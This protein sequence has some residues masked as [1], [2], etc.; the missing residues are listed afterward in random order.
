MAHARPSR[1]LVLF[2]GD[3]AEA[4]ISRLS[5]RAVADAL[6]AAG[7]HVRAVDLPR[8]DAESLDAALAAG[9]EDVVFPALHGPW[10]EGG[11]LQDLLAARGRA[12]VGADAETARLCM[13]KQRTKERAA[14]AGVPVIEGGVVGPGEPSP[15]PPPAVVK[16]V[17]DGS[18][19]DLV[20]ADDAAALAEALARIT[21]RRGRV[22]VERRIRGR[23]ITVGMLNGTALPLV[24]IVPAAGAYDYAAKYE[25]ADTRYRTAPDDL[26]AAVADAAVR[27]AET[28]WAAL[29]L[30]DLAR[31]DFMV[32]GD[33]PRLLEV[34]TMPGFTARSLLPRAAAAAGYDLPRL[35]AHLADLAAARGAP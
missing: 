27:A 14:A 3:D 31:V 18:S 9:D 30:R 8:G 6:L 34:N 17:D 29:G 21:A 23:E 4:P 19:V 25:R 5:G 35:T 10:G 20:L 28:V 22:L 7:R 32:D 26:P 33:T 12:F 1:V 15:V 24:E 2:G 13:D 11:P 16:P